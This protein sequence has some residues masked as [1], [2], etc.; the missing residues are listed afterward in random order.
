[1]DRVKIKTTQVPTV[2]NTLL[3]KQ[4]GLCPLCGASMGAAKTKKNPALDHD[5][6]TGIIRDVLCI[7]CNGLEGKIWNLLRR[8]KKD[9]AREVLLNLQ[10]YYER[11]DLRPHGNVIHPTHKTPAEKRAAAN[12]KARLKRAAIKKG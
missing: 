11:H 5:H 7:N 3:L 9:G 2:R 1:V 6:T 10:K 4:K 8:M 12:R